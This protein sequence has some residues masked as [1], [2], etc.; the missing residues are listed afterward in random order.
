MSQFQGGISR[1]AFPLPT[2]QM[3]TA[4]YPSMESM[5]HEKV[6][7]V[8]I[9]KAIMWHS[10]QSSRS[11]RY[12]YLQQVER[13]ENKHLTINRKPDLRATLLSWERTTQCIKTS[14]QRLSIFLTSSTWLPC[15]SVS[16]VALLTAVP[17]ITYIRED[18]VY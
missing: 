4:R 2:L 14:V 11:L 17:K 18:G 16:C 15:Y 1:I 6:F 5:I 7:L 8:L 12:P 3:A 10:S 13:G 9:T